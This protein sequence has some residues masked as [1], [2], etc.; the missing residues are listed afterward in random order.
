MKLDDLKTIFKNSYCQKDIE[1][2]FLKISD[3]KRSS[4]NKENKLNLFIQP[5]ELETLK[6]EINKHNISENLI[7][8]ITERSSSTR[9][10]EKYEEKL[11]NN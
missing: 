10:K 3:E 8:E 1:N 11:K 7:I 5:S 6:E 4:R 9:V 2:S